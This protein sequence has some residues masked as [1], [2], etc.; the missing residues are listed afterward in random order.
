[1]YLLDTNVISELRKQKPHGA[2]VAWFKSVSE[3][4]LYLCAPTI[5]QIQRGIEITN[6]Q[7]RERAIW[8]SAWLDEISINYNV[9]PMDGGAFR[10]YAKLMHGRSGALGED[11]MI[12][13]IAKS[14][15][16]TVVT[17]NIRDFGAFGVD[18]LNPFT[19]AQP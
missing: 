16:L 2:V 18:I 13:A 8:L 10:L 11:G 6:E 17:R 19:P 7:D 4:A 3:N 15:G 9:L 5:G 1:M 14:N 12:A